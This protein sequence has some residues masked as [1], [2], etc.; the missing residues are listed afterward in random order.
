MTVLPLY[1]GA[2]EVLTKNTVKYLF[3]NYW[4]QL[5]HMTENVAKVMASVGR[6][7]AGK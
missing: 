7:A 3:V 5:K 6:P 4:E 2:E 1:G